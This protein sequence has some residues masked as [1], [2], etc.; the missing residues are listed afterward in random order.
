MPKA[1]LLVTMAEQ[2]GA[3][4]L[5]K[6]LLCP[7]THLLSLTCLPVPR[8]SPGQAGSPPLPWEVVLVTGGQCHQAKATSSI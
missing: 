2:K 6:G 3:G 8:E 7:G 1:M 5:R 4:T